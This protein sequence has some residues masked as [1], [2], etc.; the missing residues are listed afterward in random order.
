MTDDRQPRSEPDADRAAARVIRNS[1]IVAAAAAVQPIPLVDLALLTPIQ[2][3]MVRTV[4][5]IYGHPLGVRN[6]LELIGTFGTSLI[7]QHAV[8]VAVKLVP[9]AGL[10]VA[11]SV[12][13]ALT[14]AIGETARAHFRHGH[15]LTSANL[16]EV[17]RRAYRKKRG[18]VR[19]A[20]RSDAQLIEELRRLTDD[21]RGGAIGEAEYERRKQELIARVA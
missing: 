15:A 16:R 19:H 12:A 4:A 21:R 9:V 8:M 3:G 14:Y 7:A 1:S 10:P 11:V 6:A 18:E 2:V 20:A 17:F 5:A 13:Y